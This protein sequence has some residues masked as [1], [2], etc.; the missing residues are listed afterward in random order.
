MKL[1]H[2]WD[3]ARTADK[4]NGAPD[5]DLKTHLKATAQENLP[6]AAL[7]QGCYDL[8]RERGL[9]EEAYLRGSIGRGHADVHSDIDLFT[10]V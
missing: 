5:V 9:L 4:T 7:L 1:K 2:A 10:V 6:Q 3:T 8:L